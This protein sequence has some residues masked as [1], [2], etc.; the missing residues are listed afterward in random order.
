MRGEDVFS[1]AYLLSMMG[2]PPHARGRRPFG[3]SR[4][5]RPRITPRMRG[6][7]RPGIFESVIGSGSPPHARGRPRGQDFGEDRRRI[8]PACAGK[9]RI[10]RSS[11]V[12]ATDHP[13]MRGEDAAA[14][15]AAAVLDGSPPHARGRQP[16]KNQRH[17]CDGITPACA[18]KTWTSGIR[19]F[20]R[21]DHPRMRGEDTTK[22][23]IFTT[24]PGSPPHARGRPAVKPGEIECSRITP[25]CAGK[26]TLSRQ[27]I[28][29]WTDHPRMRGEDVH[30]GQSRRRS[31]GSPPHARGRLACDLLTEPAARITPAC[32]GKTRPTP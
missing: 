2:S 30:G 7:D 11:G 29:A 20:R 8:T 17:H 22:T 5:S 27:R 21:W 31:V 13:R 28:Y 24:P 10:E 4:L 26:T 15:A 12:D 32:A 16:G 19:R 18:G 9:T 23:S 14:I 6:E 1:G 3:R 25:A